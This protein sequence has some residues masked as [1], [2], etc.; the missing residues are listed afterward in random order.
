MTAV[1]PR[2]SPLGNLPDGVP[3]MMLLDLFCGAGGAAVGYHRAG[4]DVVGVDINPQPNYPFEFVMADAIEQ[5]HELV[6]HFG[7]DAIHASPP[8]QAFVSLRK[9]WNA[10]D[11]PNLLAPVRD[12]LIAAGRPYV[13]ENVPGSPIRASVMLCGSQFGLGTE[14][15]ELR[16]HRYFETNWTVG[17]VP[18]CS[19]GWLTRK[20]ITVVG[21][22]HG[23][24]NDLRQRTIG[25]YCQ[26]FSTE[27][28]KRAMGIDW[29]NGRE[30]S[31]AVPPA[32]TEYIG[33][34]LMG[35]LSAKDVGGA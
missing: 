2:R 8:C 28:R 7:P 14:D 35:F 10:K 13:I 3:R 4:F 20:T 23:H 15:A 11:H 18:P 33:E 31:Q 6:H 27:D 32:Y 12:L 16:R 24:L 30:L 19:H 1:D 25:V 26:D 21:H 9:M 34:R 22:A 29:M 5:F 17:L